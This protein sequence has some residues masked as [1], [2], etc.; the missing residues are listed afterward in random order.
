MKKI[1]GIHLLIDG[2]VKNGNILN[3]ENICSL[4]DDLVDALKMQY[5]MKPIITRVAIDENKLQ[6]DEDE[7]GWSGICQITTSHIS[8]HAWPLRNAF[9]MDIFSCKE[10]NAEKALNIVREKFHLTHYNISPI[11]RKDPVF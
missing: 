3:P 2:Y 5:L 6:T 9:M 11:V 10:F 8:I 1:F 7:G 4:F